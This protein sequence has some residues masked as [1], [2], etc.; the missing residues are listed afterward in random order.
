MKVKHV[1]TIFL[2]L[3]LNAC[4]KEDFENEKKNLVKDMTGKVELLTIENAQRQVSKWLSRVNIL[5]RES[6]INSD[7]CSVDS[8]KIT[9]CCEQ[10][11]TISKTDV[12]VYKWEKAQLTERGKGSTN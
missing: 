3:S 2:L 12:L 1:L 11:K 4:T 7:S 8:T 5:G 6:F 10:H 9:Q